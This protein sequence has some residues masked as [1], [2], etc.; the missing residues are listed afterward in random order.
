MEAN[1]IHYLQS[2]LWKKHSS[3]LT[4]ND[5]LFELGMDSLQATQFRRFIVDA[6]SRVPHTRHVKIPRDF[7]YTHSSI[8]QIAR[9]LRQEDAVSSVSDEQLLQDLMDQYASLPPTSSPVDTKAT[10]LLTGGTGALG[11]HLVATLASAPWVERIIVLN[12]A[13][14][15][16]V[17]PYARQ[18]DSG[19]KKG[20]K[21]PLAV[22][23]K[24][25]VI[26][27]NTAL[28]MLGLSKP[29][30]WGVA[31]ATTHILHNAWPVDFR[32]AVTSF[33][34]Q[35]NIMS[36]LLQLARDMQSRPSFV[37]LS[38]VAV[39]AECKSDMFPIPETLCGA[40]WALPKMG[41]G[42]AKLVCERMLERASEEGII[43]GVTVRFGQISG[44]V[45]N[46]YWNPSEYFPTL[47]KN[48]RGIGLLPEL[49]GVSLRSR[50][51]HMQC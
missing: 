45:S 37:F 29:R 15:N 10:I 4:I 7:L 32:R 8:G 1:L 27:T 2:N 43:N 18:F 13:D 46:G 36:N 38:S 40:D 31:S 33:K 19:K 11:S 25:E 26:E 12:R 3:P 44:A 39:V 9:Y 14:S 17:N 6:V 22:I 5:D 16:G 20:T 28:P 47:V 21:I 51:L 24:V 48:S 42:Q 41:Y 50:V 35:F 34:S 30:Y 49:Q 23:D